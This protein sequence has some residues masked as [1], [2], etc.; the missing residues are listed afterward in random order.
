LLLAGH[1]I[2]FHHGNYEAVIKRIEA[3]SREK[4]ITLAVDHEFRHG[5]MFDYY[6]HNR[7]QLVDRSSLQGT[8]TTPLQPEWYLEHTLDWATSPAKE[9]TL[10]NHTTYILDMVTPSTP[11]SGWKTFL[12]RKR[13]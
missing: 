8:N 7:I 1:L 9:I 11:L 6:G 4:S 2:W 13:V 12:Y 5:M 10:E 3:S